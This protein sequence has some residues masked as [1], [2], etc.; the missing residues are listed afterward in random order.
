MAY[1]IFRI[2]KIVL[3]TFIYILIF[4]FLLLMLPAV[5][6]KLAAWVMQRINEDYKVDIQ[7]ER[8]SISL[9][10][11]VG[12]DGVLIRDH[13]HDT[14]IAVHEIRTPLLDLKAVMNGNLIFSNIE[15]DGLMMDMKTYKGDTLSNLD[16]FV[17][18]FDSGEPPSKEPFIMKANTIKLKNGYFRVC[19][20]NTTA[21]ESPILLEVEGIA[22]QISD[23]EI[24]D[25]DVKLQLKH[26]SL[27][28]GKHLK[29]D[30]LSTNFHYA[31]TLISID[32]TLLKTPFSTI[33]A[34]LSF[35][36]YE[37][38]YED[39]LN[40]VTLKATLRNSLISTNDLNGFYNGF[41]MEKTLEA[42]GEFSGTLNNL[43]IKDIH[44]YHE[45]TAIEGEGILLKNAFSPE[46]DFVFWGNFPHFSSS[47]GDIAALMPKVLG[48]SLPEDLRY[49]GLFEGQAELT[50]T[51][52][53]LLIDTDVF[54]QRGDFILSGSFYNLKDLAEA[55]Y[56]GKL[57]TYQLKVGELFKITDLGD[58]SASL[59][60]V[61]KG[62]DF[63]KLDKL[64]LHGQVHS[65]LYNNY[66]Y[67]DIKFDAEY[68]Q[69]KIRAT[70]SIG[71]DNLQMDFK[72]MADITSSQRSN[73]TL[74]G[75]MKYIDLKALGFIQK[76][77]IAKV[78]GNID[79]DIT[80]NSLDNM[81]GRV[82]LKNASYQKNDQTYNFA[83]FAI[84]IQKDTTSLRTITLESTDIISGKIQGEFKFAQ[85]GQVLVNTLAYGFENY[86]PFKVMQGQYLTFDF[87]IYN[88]I[89]ELFL[90]ELSFAPNTFIRG[91]LVGDEHDFKL[92]F[93]SAYINISDY[94]LRGVNLEYDKKNP[95]YRSLVQISSL[96]N[97]YYKID[98]FNMVNTSVND[99][100]FFQTEFKGGRNSED[101]YNLRFY[102]T[103]NP[104]HESEVGIKPS[105]YI[106]FK[107]NEWKIDKN[108]ENKLVI[109][110]KMDSLQIR[111]ISLR[112]GEESISF[113]ARIAKENNYK[114]LH[115]VFDK[116]D[117]DKIIPTMDNLSV[118]GQ[119][120]GHLSL[121]QQKEKYYPTADL[122]LK[123]LV[124]NKYD[125]GDLQASIVGD[126]SLSSFKASLE[127]FN[128]LGEG[129]QLYG[130]IFLKDNKTY[131]DLQSYITE[132]NLAPFAPFTQD[133]LSNLHG[134]LT[135]Q[136]KVIGLLTKP[137]IEGDFVLSKAGVGVPY[138]NIDLEADD[139]LRIGLKDNR[140]TIKEIPLT[141]TA[142]KTKVYLSGGA[143]YRSL[144][145]WY[146]DL[147]FDTKGKRFLALNTGPKD[148][149]LFYGTGF[150]I[151]KASIKGSL[152]DLT[153]GV[154]AVTGEGTKFKIPLSDTQTVGDDSFITFISKEKQRKKQLITKTYQGLEMNFEVDVLPS[155]EVE[156]IVDPKNNSN[157]IGRG[158]GTLL[159]EINTTGKF[160]MWGDFITTSG[161]Y[162]FKYEGLIDKKF[163]VLPNGSISW[164]GDP[165]GATLQN[166][167]AAYNL[168]VNPS[169][170]LQTNLNR[171]IQTQ[172]LINLQ[173]DLAHP[174]T[175][176]DIKF[177]D[178]SP[179]L[180]S[181]LNYHLEDND[182]KQLQ[183]F[184]LLAQGSFLSDATAGEKMLS[185]NVLETAAG[186]FNQLLSSDDDKLNLGVSYES[187]TAT[188]NRAYNSSD[189]LGITVSTQVTD[190]IFFNGK[191]G[192]PVGGVTQ[193]AVAGDFELQFLLSKDGR[194]SAKIFNRE[195]ELQQYLMDKIDYSQGIGLTY[196]VDFDTF[197]ELIRDI[198]AK[199]KNK[200]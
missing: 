43:S 89:I 59:Q 135:G 184:S 189:R 60:F 10:G 137:Q 113:N 80:G 30:D 55:T 78:K 108:R 14:L 154:K 195:N 129:L 142:Y 111:P 120:N 82:L 138:L 81:V 93:R 6:T 102:H 42:E 101:D 28:Y 90:P 77:S 112:H 31:D 20:F 168:Y 66:L 87:K 172:V 126:E 34:D 114:D 63:N 118:G 185:Y 97:P 5:Q 29:V 71:D 3:K 132:L 165:M 23:F 103:I 33:D 65:A 123:Q 100:L 152:D 75:E 176:F 161:E 22:G 79:L 119:L 99:T 9:T 45:S 17:S 74:S 92:N 153:I 24:E 194:L 122:S 188:P 148:N 104:K 54:T 115:L 39:F 72:G 107:G 95:T 13:H 50:Y 35:A 117:I 46:K 98:E 193:T 175:V 58:I 19:D 12:L 173:G 47:Y 139:V 186:I 116:V 56:K 105:S 26:G 166:L 125:L 73:Y 157:L 179:S 94:S 124:L 36:P 38:S 62:L 128:L 27:L 61:G 182:K 160:N 70:A 67:K 57:D 48:E 136:A 159:L 198:F 53:D 164:N 121:V 167:G 200:K 91:K 162:N 40:K 109:N 130:K 4:T 163:K 141:D 192:I 145:D 52:R 187:G 131:L 69:K 86:K 32:K 149:D 134:A 21:G 197:R 151:G 174:Q 196:K 144:S 1:K 133:I 170:L 76:D 16:V 169:T 2:V 158:A 199:A 150:I 96:Q 127:F 143:G 7:V 147:N 180:V 8:V 41:A 181:E 37:G 140:F 171:K 155:A 146:I 106:L 49:F 178:S 88:K 11:M 85:I 84:N 191:L 25:S 190:R 183:A 44:L 68:F 177:P 156:I 83:D 18:R 15:A 51:T 110:R 64:S